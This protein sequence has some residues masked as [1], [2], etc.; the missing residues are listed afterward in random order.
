MNECDDMLPERL[1]RELRRE[2]HS[3]EAER[4]RVMAAVHRDALA[5]RRGGWLA[6]VAGLAIAAGLVLGVALG[7]VER[8]SP[9]AGGAGTR[10]GATTAIDTALRDTLMLIRFAIASPHA[11]R[12]VLVGD[13]NGWRAGA[14]ALARGPRGDEW[15]ATVAVAPGTHRYAFVVNDTEWVT[16]LPDDA[17]APNGRRASRLLVPK[18]D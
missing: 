13:F 1:R 11:A 18:P 5:T 6:P 2:L 16:N 7:P 17:T 14:T 15:T 9:G 10:V 8:W 4:R 12:V 3:T